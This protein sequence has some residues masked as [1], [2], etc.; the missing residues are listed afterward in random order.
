VAGEIAASTWAMSSVTTNAFRWM[1]A[2]ASVK[3]MTTAS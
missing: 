1:G 2:T 3:F